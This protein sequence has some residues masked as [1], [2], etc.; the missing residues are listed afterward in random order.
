MAERKQATRTSRTVVDQTGAERTDDRFAGEDGD[1]MGNPPMDG[2]GQHLDWSRVDE[3]R[4]Q[5]QEESGRQDAERGA[6]EDD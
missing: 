3:I 5:R 2:A 6:G 1:L 4:G